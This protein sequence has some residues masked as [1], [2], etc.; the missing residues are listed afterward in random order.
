M[1]ERIEYQQRASEECTEHFSQA[2]AR[3]SV[4]AEKAA[5]RK[6]KN[7]TT[8]RLSHENFRFGPCTDTKMV[9]TVLL[10]QN[11]SIFEV[12]NHDRGIWRVS[13][14]LKTAHNGGMLDWKI[15]GHIPFFSSILVG[16][17]ES[18][19]MCELL[20]KRCRGWKWKKGCSKAQ[21]DG[22]QWDEIRKK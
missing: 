6:E 1:S 20:W 17:R 5:A 3:V 10:P 13:V 12:S 21:S 7:L 22:E 11:I 8:N 18:G 19:L 2:R 16:F 9:K 14:V 15:M 4:V